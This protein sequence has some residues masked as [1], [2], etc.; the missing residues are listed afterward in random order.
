[1][2]KDKE[3]YTNVMKDIREKR[4]KKPGNDNRDSSGVVLFGVVLFIL[5]ALIGL[6]AQR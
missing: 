4:K 3:F 5:I 1:M 2:K 6:M